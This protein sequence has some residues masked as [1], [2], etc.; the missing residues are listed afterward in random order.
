MLKAVQR[1]TEAKWVL[2]YVTR[3]LKAPMQ[4]DGSLV[5]RDRGTPQG[6]SI[7]P[8]LA[9]LFLHY[10]LDVWLSR[11]FPSVPFER[12]C[13]DAV[14]H[15]TSQAQAV[16]VRDALAARL[17]DVGLEFASG[18]D[19]RWCTAR[20]PTGVTIMRLRRSR[21]WATRSVPDWPKP[22]GGSIS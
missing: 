9:N 8:V 19:T 3:W 14:I 16:L 20:T 2:L 21:S 18:Q 12:Y 15:C 22:G 6:S 4:Q 17:A 10:A 7:S 5:A 13:D 1:H 11:E